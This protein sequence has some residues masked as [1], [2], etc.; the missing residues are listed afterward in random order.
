MRFL[1]FIK[2]MFESAIMALQSIVS[3]KLRTSLSI[4][5]ISIGIFSIITVFTLVDSL[6]KTVKKGFETMGD[7]VIFV[8]KFPWTF[9][10]DY[11]MWK[12][13]NR[14]S[15]SLDDRQSIERKGQK[16]KI[17]YIVYVVGYQGQTVKYKNISVE[18][19]VVAAADYDY[20]KV[21]DFEVEKGRYFSPME[22]GVGRNVALIGAD[23]AE[24]LFGTEYPIG[25]SVKVLG[26]KVS[27]IGVLK[28]Q[29]QNLFGKTFDNAVITPVNFVGQFMNVQDPSV[30]PAVLVKGEDD[31]NTDDLENELVKVLRAKRKLK[32]KQENNFA[33][34]RITMLADQISQTF[35]VISIAGGAIGFFAILVGGFGI[36]NIMF[37]SVKERT[38]IIGI[39]K[40]L[41]AK[42]YFVL[43]E[44]LTESIV[45]CL[46]GGLIGMGLVFLVTK[47]I[48]SPSFEVFMSVGNFTTGIIISVTIGL[49]A[50]F[51]PALKASKMVPVEAMRSK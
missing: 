33:L 13:A 9:T 10:R 27:V 22:S 11:P 25:K 34:N 45:L 50:G 30:N 3:H 7:N 8:S 35:G 6:E 28:R 20:D 49:I 24:S 39:Q 26:R 32:P 31:V 37:V 16:D 18:N 44:F 40:A 48:S 17:K 51:A 38:H 23:V 46:V 41:G 15:P 14:P 21:N 19:I 12:Y 43:M 47:G 5:G 36:A 29:G 4:M 2:L 42:N 1:I